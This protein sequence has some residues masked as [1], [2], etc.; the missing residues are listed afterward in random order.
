MCN[1]HRTVM[2]LLDLV[3]SIATCI[4]T[5]V[6][7]FATTFVFGDL[8][9]WH[10]NNGTPSDYFVAAAQSFIDELEANATGHAVYFPDATL[11]EYHNLVRAVT[12][13]DSLAL[14]PRP[15]LN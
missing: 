4:C 15:F 8:S 2:P 9:S 3:F 6:Y 13:Q 10:N 14:R 5:S 7:E 1:F 11:K 12:E